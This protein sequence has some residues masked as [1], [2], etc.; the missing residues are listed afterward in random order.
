MP[1][2]AFPNGQRTQ[3]ETFILNS[4]GSIFYPRWNQLDI[5]L[6]KNFRHNNKV[7]T[8]QI[9]VF[10]LLNSNAMRGANNSVGGSLGNATTIMLGR[11][12]RLALNYKF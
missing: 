10:N 7:L 12:P 2:S 11:F 5:N 9:D 8:L 3:A 1:A 6:K 4:P